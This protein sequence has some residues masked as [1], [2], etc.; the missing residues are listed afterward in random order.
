MLRAYFD[1]SGTHV[2]SPVVV[3]GGLLGRTENWGKLEDK[4]RA[5]LASP[6]EGK[7]RLKA[8]HSSHCVNHWGEFE[9]YSPAESDAI[10]YD[11]RQI[12]LDANLYFL[13]TAIPRA[14]WDELVVSPYRDF[15]GTAEEACF[16]RF[17]QS[18]IDKV[19][20]DGPANL[21]IAFFYDIG[22]KTERIQYLAGLFAGRADMPEF[23]SFS[24]VKAQEVLPLQAADLIANEHYRAVQK[25][26]EDGH[27]ER[28]DPHAQELLRGMDGKRQILDREAIQAEINRRGADG[29][30]LIYSVLAARPS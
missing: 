23:A 20:S 25:W 13:S 24:L 6:L 14:D 3:L 16:T 19:Q 27:V 8:F 1:D 30:L 28:A 12:I 17:I 22:R 5:K 10:R 4:W 2:G 26:I 18:S 29:T 11:F 9:N 7:P 21:K 15:M